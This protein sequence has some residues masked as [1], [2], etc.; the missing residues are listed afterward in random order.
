MIEVTSAIAK[1]G[2]RVRRWCTRALVVLGGTIAGAAITVA[3]SSASAEAAHESTQ[4]EGT[5]PASSSEVVNWL[6]SDSDRDLRDVGDDVRTWARSG[7]ERVGDELR[8][9]GEPHRES[10]ETRDDGDPSGTSSDSGREADD[11]GATE[12]PCPLGVT[13]ADE[14]D[15]ASLAER[16][17]LTREAVEESVVR[18]S[19]TVERVL[20]WPERAAERLGEL[21]DESWSDSWSDAL[22]DWFRP[23]IEDV[24]DVPEGAGD[25]RAQSKE[26]LDTRGSSGSE[27]HPIAEDTTGT[28]RDGAPTV[29]ESGDYAPRVADSLQGTTSPELHDV[30]AQPA[31]GASGAGSHPT[32]GSASPV[33]VMDYMPLSTLLGFSKAVDAG[34]A[35]GAVSGANQAP[36]A[37]GSQPGVTPD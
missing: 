4:G 17:E 19:A 27:A 34:K 26:D 6:D 32:T 29:I 14:T 33:Q 37:P 30:T 36:F 28:A 23:E 9:G 12:H 7:V 35:R 16:G 11:D 21:D 24:L 22:R 3:L 18:T 8:T 31:G 25:Q 20:D 1:R 15:R 10:H 2:M 5:Q 13:C